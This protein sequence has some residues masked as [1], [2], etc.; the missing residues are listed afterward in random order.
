MP[1]GGSLTI[2]TADTTLNAAYAANHEGATPGDY[3]MIAVGDTGQGMP[4]D[5][6]SKA[7]DPF[8]TTKPI[9]QGTGLGLSMI[10]GFMKQTGGHVRIGSVVGEGSTISLFL[11]VHSG[12]VEMFAARSDPTQAP[13]GAGETVLVV[14]DDRA[15]R[16]LIVEALHELG[17]DALEAADSLEALPVIESGRPIDLLITDVGLPGLNGRQL[18]EIARQT[19]PDLPIL[20]VTGYAANAAV[21]SD[22][23]GPGMDMIAKPFAMDDLA[24]RIRTIIEG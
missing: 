22:F 20:F 12:D 21:R 5:V 2:R 4:A 18:A 16:L 7:F 13:R 23:L 15:V 11:P 6:I 1:D 17:Y 9:G 14:E 19:R 8:Y 24:A 3:V 10:Y